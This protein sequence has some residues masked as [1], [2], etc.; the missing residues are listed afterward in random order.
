MTAARGSAPRARKK[1]AIIVLIVL[2]AVAAVGIG[3]VVHRGLLRRALLTSSDVPVGSVRYRPTATPSGSFGTP[4][5]VAT[6]IPIWNVFGDARTERGYVPASIIGPPP[7]PTAKPTPPPV[8]PPNPIANP[9]PRFN[10]GGANGD[11]PAR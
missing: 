1:L 8:E 5:P 4:P 3:K 2:L 9:P 10:P 6:S 7:P 11:R